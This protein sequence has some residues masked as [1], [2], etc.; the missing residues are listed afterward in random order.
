MVYNTNTYKI[1]NTILSNNSNNKHTLLKALML[2]GDNLLVVHMQSA[3]YQ[4]QR[5]R[6]TATH[7]RRKVHQY[8]SHLAFVPLK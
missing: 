1:D 3:R 2:K 5:G 4:T 6:R 8:G 7:V